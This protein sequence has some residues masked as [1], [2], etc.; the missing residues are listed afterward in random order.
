MYSGLFL[1]DIYAFLF[2]FWIVLLRCHAQ[3]TASPF[4]V[5]PLAVRSPY[6]NSWLRVQNNTVSTQQW[7]TGPEGQVRLYKVII[8][9]WVDL[10]SAKTLG[11]AGLVKVDNVTYSWLGNV[12]NVNACTVTNTSITPTRTIFSLRAGP[13]QLVVTFL[14][15]IEASGD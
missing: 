2:V 1:R 9:T 15:P 11:W 8:Y 3:S 12:P 4:S 13:M 5:L 7:P 14:S 6:L 10:T